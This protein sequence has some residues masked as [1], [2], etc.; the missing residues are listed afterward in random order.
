ML[1]SFPL[2]CGVLMVLV[3]GTVQFVPRTIR[4]HHVSYRQIR[5]HFADLRLILRLALSKKENSEAAPAME[6]KFA[7]AS[8]PAGNS[9]PLS[10]GF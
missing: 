1:L 8:R 3:H 2:L 5:T 10:A 9:M 6:K 7:K 4:E